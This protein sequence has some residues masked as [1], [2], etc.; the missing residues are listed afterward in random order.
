MR[1]DSAEDARA[2]LAK[3]VNPPSSEG[4]DLNL[5]YCALA[6]SCVL[7]NHDDMTSH[8]RHFEEMCDKLAA[9]YQRCLRDGEED[10]VLLRHQCIVGV[11]FDDAGYR[12]DE[13]DFDNLDNADM[14][15]VVERRKGLP[16]ALA[17]LYIQLAKSQNWQA[18]GTSFPGYFVLRLCHGSQ[19]ILVDAFREGKVLEAGDLRQILKVFVGQNAELSQDYY[20]DVSDHAVLVRLQNNL[21]TRLIDL[22]RYQD[23]LSVVDITRVLVPDEYRLYFDAAMLKVKVGQIKGAQE[24]VCAYLDA[25]HDQ[26]ERQLG[27]QLLSEIQRQMN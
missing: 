1:I 7:N 24:D 10:T 11:L 26:Y 14:F 23:A 18:T 19:H 20:N 6:F 12:G 15:Y 22:E 3:M 9:L 2:Y 17:I 25:T 27:E 13:K 4:Q 16:V 21:K 8:I 5:Y